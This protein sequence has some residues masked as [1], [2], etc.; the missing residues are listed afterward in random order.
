MGA[1]AWNGRVDTS[2]YIKDK[3]NGKTI[4]IYSIIYTLYY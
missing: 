4:M 1:R 3:E 2:D